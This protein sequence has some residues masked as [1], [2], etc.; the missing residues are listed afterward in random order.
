M[1]KLLY[2]DYNATSPVLT[3]VYEAMLPYLQ[4]SF[5]NPSS[6]HQWG[7]RARVAIEQ[8]RET[9]ARLINAERNDI[10]F[11]SGGSEANNFCILGLAKKLTPGKDVLVTST[12]EHSSIM[13]IFRILEEQGFEIVRLNP[14]RC[15]MIPL[16]LFEKILDQKNV[17]LVSIMAANNEIGTLQDI[18]VLS[19]LTKNKGA[20]F[21]TDAVQWMGRLP[22][23]IKIWNVDALSAS[24]HKMGTPKGV[25]FAY[26][27]PGLKLDPL[28]YGGHHERDMRAGT[29]NVAGIVGLGKAAT[30]ACD[31]RIRK[32]QNLEKLVQKLEK[33]LKQNIA[34]L[35][36]NGAIE[37][38][39]PNTSNITFFGI[40]A[41]S[42]IMNLDMDG[43]GVS[44]GSACLSGGL[45]PS[46]VLLAL[47]LDQKNAL[48]TIR[49]SIG[50][51]WTDQD[52]DYLIG[53]ILYWVAYQKRIQTEIH[54]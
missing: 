48:S 28:I 9:V 14:D 23:D 6:I 18:P 3:E 43:I 53:R 29:E 54:L 1:K 42:L 46:H 49:I 24:G 10:I 11:T 40:N 25:G 47:G 16:D 33:E 12:I 39:L 30:V 15:G 32:W 35:K 13:E 50:P 34:D 41:E 5:G 52:I 8:A 4:E 21:H 31:G 27:A 2:G 19:K 37:S 22:L 45:E 26:L 20:Y 51:E 36:I 17:K 7:R 44:A 38:R